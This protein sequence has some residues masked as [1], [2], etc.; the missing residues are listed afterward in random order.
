MKVYNN[1]GGNMRKKPRCV[2]RVK[3]RRKYQTKSGLVRYVY[4]KG[5][6]EDQRCLRSINCPHHREDNARI[7]EL[8]LQ[9]EEKPVEVVPLTREQI[10]AAINKGYVEATGRPF[11]AEEA[12]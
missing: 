12:K 9:Y 7:M 3:P 11:F 6:P 2:G 10:R 4:I 1:K 5:T 8:P